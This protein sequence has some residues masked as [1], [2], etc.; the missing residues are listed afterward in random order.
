M[1]LKD[2]LTKEQEDIRQAI[3]KFVDK[4]IMPI[5]EKLEEDY[6]LV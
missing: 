3:R 2:L 4:E 6:S 5:R 1:Y